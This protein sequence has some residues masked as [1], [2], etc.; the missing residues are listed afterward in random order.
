MRQIAVNIADL[1][2]YDRL[3][4]S[5]MVAPLIQDRRTCD[6][7]PSRLDGDCIILAC[8]E[9]RARA[10]VGFLRDVDK[11]ERQYAVRAYAS[12]PRGGWTRF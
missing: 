8:A 6:P 3:V 4:C 12:G 9:D 1:T 5:L 10:V 7:Q 2:R 11:R